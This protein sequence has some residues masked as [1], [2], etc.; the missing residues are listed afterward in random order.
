M[1]HNDNNI[2]KNNSVNLLTFLAKAMPTGN[3]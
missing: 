2:D 3:H 1:A